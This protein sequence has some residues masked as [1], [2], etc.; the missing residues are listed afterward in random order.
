M[1]M[2]L[3]V[4]AFITVPVHGVL[5]KETCLNTTHVELEYNYTLTTAGSS[6]DYVYTQ[7]HHCTNNC[8]NNKCEATDIR[9]NITPVWFVYGLGTLLLSL[10]T[11]LGIPFG[12]FA[13]K[14][15]EFETRKEFKGGFDTRMVVRYMFFFVGFYLL[16]LSGSMARRI[17]YA[18]GGRG[19]VTSATGTATLVMM[20]TMVLFLFVF[21]I[22]SL[23]S[24]LKW[25]GE[26][27]ME[28]WRPRGM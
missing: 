26:R 23:F 22:E 4:L 21:V 10:G 13:G 6:V 8:T 18:Y 28:K 1:M 2:V 11:L 20:I 7:V 17:S 15:E 9:A 3:A 24:I 5:V 12:K 16:Y 14:E 19:D 27:K 25:M